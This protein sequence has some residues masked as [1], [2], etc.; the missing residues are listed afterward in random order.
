MYQGWTGFVSVRVCVLQKGL[1]YVF[2]VWFWLETLPSLMWL[3]SQFVFLPHSGTQWPVQLIGL[4]VT[5][6]QWWIEGKEEKKRCHSARAH[7][8][9]I[10]C[11]LHESKHGQERCTICMLKI[12]AQIFT[13]IMFSV[14]QTCARLLSASVFNTDNITVLSLPLAGRMDLNAGRLDTCEHKSDSISAF[15]K[16][17][18]NTGWQSAC[19][20]F[21]LILFSFRLNMITE[22][23][24][25]R[26]FMM[27]C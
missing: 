16:A 24:A 21:S 20:K 5:R 4:Q 25:G 13:L 10:G 26:P 23:K 17:K 27:A 11:R 18:E 6:A 9:W 14:T 7:A 1:K 12:S 15:L 8:A 2:Q 19:F 3:L 22:T